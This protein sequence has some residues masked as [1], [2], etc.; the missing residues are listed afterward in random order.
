MRSLDQWLAHQAQVHPQSI[1][2]GLERLS[3]VLER[4][5]W[6]QP[7]VPVITVAGHQRQGFGD[8]LLHRDA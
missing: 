6:R 1:D 8:R 4:L 5:E 3:A 2:L 7:P